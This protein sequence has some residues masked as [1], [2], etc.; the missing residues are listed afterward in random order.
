MKKYIPLFLVLMASCGGSGEESDKKE[1][2]G[3]PV[4]APTPGP[5]PAPGSSPNPLV[6]SDCVNDFDCDG[7][8]ITTACDANDQDAANTAYN[9]D[10]CVAPEDD[11]DGDGHKDVYCTE[12][13]IDR[14]LCDNCLTIY[15]PD[16]ADLNEDGM[17]DACQAGTAVENG[18]AAN[19]GVTT[20]GG[21]EMPGPTEA[22]DE[23]CPN[24]DGDAI[25]DEDERPG[26]A[27]VANT[28]EN[29][30]ITCAD[31]D[32]DGDYDG[33]D[34]DADD[35]G[36][37]DTLDL[38]PLHADR[39]FLLKAVKKAGMMNCDD[40]YDYAANFTVN[41]YVVAICSPDVSTREIDMVSESRAHIEGLSPKY[42]Y[43]KDRFWAGITPSKA[44]NY[45]SSLIA[46][47][48]KTVT[49]TE[50]VERTICGIFQSDAD[51]NRI[52]TACD[53]DERR[54]RFRDDGRFDIQT[55]GVFDPVRP[56]G[57]PVN[58][59]R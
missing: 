11:I 13:L 40:G 32:S 46:C 2:R 43:R 9:R 22:P 4:L 23:S 39:W 35:D 6:G 52:G 50:M 3:N 27:I 29:A 37:N 25:C 54:N 15:N 36:L 17:G 51:N 24:E 16:Q 7:D 10:V 5:G 45:V 33:P 28:V 1:E 48:E 53:P 49:G 38:C 8:G 31:T 56:F 42:Q 55:P 20:E 14:H 21:E 34:P 44:S 47:R 57:A 18:G 26:C 30:D 19:S 41:R 59:R 58:K 12:G